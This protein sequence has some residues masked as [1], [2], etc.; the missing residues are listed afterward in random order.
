MQLI[1][2]KVLWKEF[3]ITRFQ[4]LMIFPVHQGPKV[5]ISFLKNDLII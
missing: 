5:K 3:C 2:A 1:V 4:N